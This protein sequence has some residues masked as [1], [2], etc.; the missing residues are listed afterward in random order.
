MLNIILSGYNGQ[1]GKVLKGLIEE[2]DDLN[3]CFGVDRSATE[4]KFDTFNDFSKAPI[5]GDVIID[6]SH[7]SMISNLL[8]YIEKTNIPA[9]ICTTGISEENLSRINVLKE[10]TAI[11]MSGNMSLG[12][13]LLIKLVKDAAKVLEDDFDIEIIEKHHNKKVDSPSGTAYM[14]GNAILDSCSNEKT[15]IHGREGNNAKRDKKEIG[16]HAVRGG[17]IVGEHQVIFAGT[18]EIIEI[19]HKASSKKVFAKGAISAA[20]FINGKE[21]GMY[22]MNNIFGEDN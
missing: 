13:N 4:E 22:D 5:T 12:I 14:I 20:R 3:I 10:N 17:T 6:F 2:S 21:K 1:M 7:H 19:G 8:D 15:F 11:F 16:I 9:V 18:D